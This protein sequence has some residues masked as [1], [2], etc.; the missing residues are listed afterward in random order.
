VE[1]SCKHGNEPLDSLKCWEFRRVAA[2]IMGSQEG[3]SS[4]KQY[5]GASNEPSS[6]IKC[7]E[8]LE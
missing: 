4:L 7:W 3:I 6:S 8:V 5:K 2:K 1:G